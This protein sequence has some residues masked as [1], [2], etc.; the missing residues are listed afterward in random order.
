MADLA[1]SADSQARVREIATTAGARG[2]RT[3]AERVLDA[4]SMTLLF[5]AGVDYVQ[6]DFLA[7]AGP[8]MTYDFS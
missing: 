5:S 3:V 4:S 1:K 6:G 8:E 2:I 7:P